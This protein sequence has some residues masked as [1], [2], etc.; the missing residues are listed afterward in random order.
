MSIDALKQHL[1]G[2]AKDIKLNLSSVLAEEGAPGLSQQQVYMAALASAYATHDLSLVTALLNE[3]KDQL[4]PDAIDAAKSSAAIMAMNNIYYRGIH[5]I[6]DK[7]YDQMPAN[8]RM[9]IIGK[10]G[11]NKLDFELMCLAVSAINGCEMCIRAH[12]RAAVSAGLSKIAV[13]SVIRIAAVMNA[14]AQTLAIE[15][16]HHSEQSLE[17][18]A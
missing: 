5:A 17:S 15:I 13:Q 16:I 12:A 4:F 14:M 9:S 6:H 1:P 18:A 2:Y 10:S 3:S 7:D 11:V 8:L